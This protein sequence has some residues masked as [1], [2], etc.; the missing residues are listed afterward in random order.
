MVIFSSV[1]EGKWGNYGRKD[2]NFSFGHVA[3]RPIITHLRGYVRD[4]EMGK[5]SKR[6]CQRDREVSK[7]LLR[8][9]LM[10]G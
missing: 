6:T 2:Q 10:S 9:I 1:T 7:R 5:K 3:F 8:E 4:R